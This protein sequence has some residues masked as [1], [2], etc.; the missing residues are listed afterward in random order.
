MPTAIHVIFTEFVVEEI[1]SQL[2]R[3]DKHDEIAAIVDMVRSETISDVYLYGHEP[4]KGRYPKRS[5]DASLAHANSQYPS[6]IIETSY[7]H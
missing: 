6:V 1:R 3:V 4:I 5:P 7:S 2:R